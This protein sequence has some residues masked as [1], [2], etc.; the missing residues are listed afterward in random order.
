VIDGD[1]LTLIDV[2]TAR[3]TLQA[4]LIELNEA[5]LVKDIEKIVANAKQ[6]DGALRAFRDGQLVYKHIDGSPVDPTSIIRVF[7]VA[8]IVSPVPRFWAYNRRI[9]ERLEAHGYLEGCQP[10]EVL[11][12]EDFDVLMRLVRSGLTIPEILGRKLSYPKPFARTLSLVNFIAIYDDELGDRLKR[13]PSE[14]ARTGWF[15]ELMLCV[16]DWGFPDK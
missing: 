16:R 4:T 7:P 8:L 15:D 3:L 14:T 5:S 2:A 10:F 13:V 1:T 9:F 6:M 11:D 12:A